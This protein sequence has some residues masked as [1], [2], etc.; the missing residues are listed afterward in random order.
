[1]K[2]EGRGEYSLVGP[3]HG[4]CTPDRQGLKLFLWSFLMC[5]LSC[6][7]KLALQRV[8][9]IDFK[10]SSLTVKALHHQT[11]GVCLITPSYLQLLPATPDGWRPVAGFSSLLP[12]SLIPVIPSSDWLQ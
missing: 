4:M 2:Q 5:I 12:G 3:K 1:M 9:Q 10:L 7:W 6:T 11:S 8:Q